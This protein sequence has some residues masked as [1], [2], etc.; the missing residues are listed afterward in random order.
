MNGLRN[1]VLKMC[2][3]LEA[4]FCSFW[5]RLQSFVVQDLSAA[6]SFKEESARGIL[7]ELHSNILECQVARNKQLANLAGTEGSFFQKNHLDPT[8]LI[9]G[10]IGPVGQ[11]LDSCNGDIGYCSIFFVLT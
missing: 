7:A 11:I 10:P 3:T 9:A 4:T 2:G 5:F 8:S 1:D 6:N